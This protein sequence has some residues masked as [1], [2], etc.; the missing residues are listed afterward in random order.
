MATKK[1][2]A[3]VG[4]GNVGT[5]ALEAA[6]LAEDMELVGVVRRKAAPIPNRPAIRVAASVEQLGR[7]DGALLCGPTRLVG[8]QAARLLERGICTVDSFDIHGP[9]LLEHRSLLERAARRGDASAVIS[10]GWDPGADSVIRALVEAMAPQ[11]KTHTTFGP[12][13]SM[14]HSVAAKAIEGVRD[15][16]S[17]TLPAGPGIHK[18]QVFLELEAGADERK[19]ERRLRSDAYFEKDETEVVFVERAADQANT[20]HGV[21][22]EREGASGIVSGQRFHW[23]MRIDNP[24]LTGQMMVSS[25]R[26]AFRQRPGAYT[27]IEIP[28]VDF[29]PGSRGPWVRKLV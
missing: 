1:K 26:A 18:R 17:M 16:V 4:L 25:L 27:L 13:M 10:A 15:A 29:L 8:E 23:S 20:G 9:G 3:I 24:A 19:V 7:V 22:I 12:G 6:I 11:G 21:R 2:I 28:P 14:G 5:A